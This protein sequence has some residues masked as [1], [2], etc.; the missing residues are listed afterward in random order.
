MATAEGK[1]PDFAAAI[2]GARSWRLAPTLWARMG[3]ILWSKAMVNVWEDAQEKVAECDAGHPAPAKGCS[4]GVYAWY[5]PMLMKKHGYA[6]SD[7]TA[8]SGVVQG[9]GRVIRG[10]AGYWVAERVLVLAFFDDG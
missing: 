5:N 2:A 4:C 9:R 10:K 7:Y 3:G 8:I 6:P 1:A